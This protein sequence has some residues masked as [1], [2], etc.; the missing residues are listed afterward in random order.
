MN[1]VKKKKKSSDKEIK[2]NVDHAS[3]LVQGFLFNDQFK[4][5]W[6]IEVY[7]GEEELFYEEITMFQCT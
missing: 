1:I 7:F 3:G 5:I 6:H 2:K 4:V